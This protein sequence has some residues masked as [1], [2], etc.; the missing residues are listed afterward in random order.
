MIN[1]PSRPPPGYWT[2]KEINHRKW[3]EYTIP[4]EIDPLGLRLALE[5]PLLQYVKP[6]QVTRIEKLGH[7]LNNLNY[8]VDIDHPTLGK[9]SFFMRIPG[10]S[11]LP[12]HLTVEHLHGF[13]RERELKC[14]HAA[15]DAATHATWADSSGRKPLDV[16]PKLLSSIHVRGYMLYQWLDG[17]A[18]TSEL[19]HQPNFLKKIAHVLH[20][21]HDHASFFYS[22]DL[23]S[24]YLTTEHYVNLLRKHSELKSGLNFLLDTIASGPSRFGEVKAGAHSHSFLNEHEHDNNQ[25]ASK[26]VDGNESQAAPAQLETVVQQEK[27]EK[28]KNEAEKPSPSAVLDRMLAQAKRIHE[29]LKEAFDVGLSGHPTPVHNDLHPS[30]FV[31]VPN[32]AHAHG[33]HDTHDL[34]EEELHG[35]M[36]LVDYESCERGDRYYDLA[37]LVV[38]CNLQAKEEHILL[39]LYT[40]LQHDHPSP[41]P[42]IPSPPFDPKDR[43]PNP[44][45]GPMD[46]DLNM[47]QDITSKEAH[48]VEVDQHRH[49]SDAQEEQE[50]RKVKGHPRPDLDDQTL[51]Q[52]MHSTYPILN[53][54]LVDARHRLMK[55]LHRLRQGFWGIIQDFVS[56]Q[57]PEAHGAPPEGSEAE[58]IEGDRIEIRYPYKVPF[59]PKV[60]AHVHHPGHPSFLEYA[61]HFLQHAQMDLFAPETAQAIL[62]VQNNAAREREE[63]KLRLKKFKNDE[64]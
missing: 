51:E 45:E 46:A 60:M 43:T 41:A 40:R 22:P 63:V 34:G 42:G 54:E 61:K 59:E 52:Y 4:K 48:L 25:K 11:K 15:A 38:M 9:N 23:T 3:E 26:P 30:N 14:A 24:P 33:G 13:S 31:F 50:G 37:N 27:D 57:N 58:P 20:R 21:F 18:M 28:E 47:D 39:H 53:E 35:R 10:D 32:T 29:V 17:H 12:K 2:G 7:S 19:I 8:R 1:E 62:I 49:H 16:S 55:V 5:I 56:S 36:W 64:L 44:G 6:G